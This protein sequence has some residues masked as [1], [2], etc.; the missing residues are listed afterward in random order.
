M[1]LEQD[2]ITGED[3][4]QL[5]NNKLLKD[6]FSK[7]GEYI[8]QKALTCDPDNKEVAQRI[9]LS[10]QI[11]MG[12]RREIERLVETGMIAEVQLSEIEKKRRFSVFQR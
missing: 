3:A 2:R 1:T 11:L 9:I 10:K 5:L 6:A 8:D 12:I 4:K 7:V